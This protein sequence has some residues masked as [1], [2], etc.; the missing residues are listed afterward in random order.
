M[1]V[2]Q[3]G[4]HRWAPKNGSQMGC[5][6]LVSLW[7]ASF[8]CQSG[9]PHLGTNLR[10]QFYLKIWGAH[11]G[12]NLESTTGTQYDVPHLGTSLGAPDLLPNGLS[13]IGSQLRHPRVPLIVFQIRAPHIDP[14]IEVPYIGSVMWVPQIGSKMR[15]HIDWRRLTPK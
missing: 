5:S 11:L 4:S 2:P 1:G 12:D 7:V 10:S 15:P 3:I 13:L 8:R 14:Q 9:V 6:G